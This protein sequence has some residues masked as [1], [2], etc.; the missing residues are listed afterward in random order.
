MLRLELEKLE[1][2][3]TWP[4]GKG[5]ICPSW[6]KRAV[7]SHKQVPIS[8]AK[9]GLILAMVVFWVGACFGWAQG[10][11]VVRIPSPQQIRLPWPDMRL[12]GRSLNWDRTTG[13]YA[14]LTFENP[15]FYSRVE[16]H[17]WRYDRASFPGV[18]YDDKTGVF[19]VSLPKG[20]RVA[21]AKRS[22]GL[23]GSRIVTTKNARVCVRQRR[24]LVR[25][26]LEAL[27]EG[28]SIPKEPFFQLGQLGGEWL[29]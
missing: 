21:V 18:L 24:G 7:L 29:F 22:S 14:S 26:V 25:V 16:W 5:W 13:L 2:C 20:G 10:H 15:D 3:R 1:A 12:V 4:V 17:E 23:L 28:S 11:I 27:P 6:R 8:V 19:Y 9:L